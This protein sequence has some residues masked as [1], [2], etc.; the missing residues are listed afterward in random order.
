VNVAWVQFARDVGP[1]RPALHTFDRIFREVREHGGNTLRLWLHTNGR[2]TP[3]WADSTVVGPGATTIEDLRA[4]LNVAREHEV[5]LILCLWSFDMLRKKYGPQVTD[6]S[7]HL[8]TDPSLTQAYVDNA[9]VPMVRAVHDHPSVRAWEILNE[10]EGMSHRFGWDFTRHVPMSAVQRFINRTA[11]AIHRVD[12]DALVTTS[13]WSFKSLVD[14]PPASVSEGRKPARPSKAERRRHR[15]VLSDHYRR[16]FD[17][18][19]ARAARRR[20]STAE[21]HPYYTD[22]RLIAAGGDPKGTLDFYSVHYHDWAGRRWS[23]FLANRAHWSEEKPI[24]VTEFVA[25]EHHDLAWSELSITLFRRGY[26]GA[27]AWQWRDGGAQWDRALA[28]VDRVGT[29]QS[30]AVGVP[31]T[32]FRLAQNYP[33]PFERETTVWYDLAERV[34]VTLT[35]YDPLGRPVRTLVDEEQGPGRYVVTVSGAGLSSGVYVYR[36]RA[37]AYTQARRMVLVR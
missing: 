32:Q 6:R 12:P 35:L 24:V 31:P 26:A 16:R 3:A 7:Y 17:R 20:L 33:N 27:L 8:L 23:P 10:P 37:G 25:T 2:Y 5:G 34:P 21:A 15:R 4:I 1:G 19:E 29:M 30:A 11:G 9:L 13:A 28:N 14:T 36:L 18:G 22:E